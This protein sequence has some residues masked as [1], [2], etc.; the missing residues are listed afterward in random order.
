MRTQSVSLT[1]TNSPIGSLS[2]VKI[3]STLQK[4]CANPK[5]TLALQKLCA[6]YTK[7][8]SISV[9]MDVMT[10]GK[11]D[12]MYYLNL[13]KGVRVVGVRRSSRFRSEDEVCKFVSGESDCVF[14]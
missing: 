11:F 1:A 8:H 14:Q 4:L 5:F 12:D 7:D 9:F 6:N 3:H 10:S 2:S 13:K